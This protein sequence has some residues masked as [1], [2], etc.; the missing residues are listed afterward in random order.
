MLL[1]GTCHSRNRKQAAP[2]RQTFALC[3]YSVSV[4]LALTTLS[5]AGADLR[6]LTATA[7]TNGTLSLSFNS[8]PAFYYFL[9]AG[10]LGNS[11]NIHQLQ[12]GR[13]GVGC[14]EEPLEAS[15]SAS[16]FRIG[17]IPVT[18]PLDTDGDGIDDVYEL[19]RSG[20]LNPMDPRDAE[21]T[22]GG[23][24]SN[25]EVYRANLA[26]LSSYQREV[27]D[28]RFSLS[29][30]RALAI[31]DEGSLWAWGGRPVGDG[32]EDSKTFPVRLGTNS[33]VIA[34]ASTFYYSYAL[35]SDGTLW[36]WPRDYAAA[37]KIDP[38][39]K[40]VSLRPGAYAM[41]SDG[42]WWKITGS[43]GSEPNLI[44]I[45]HGWTSIGDLG[46]NSTTAS[47]IGVKTDG[48]LWHVLAVK[49][50][51]FPSRLGTGSNWVFASASVATALAIDAEHH[52]YEWH[53][54]VIPSSFATARKLEG[55]WSFTASAPNSGSKVGIKSDGS[56]WFWGGIAVLG[57]P[58][59]PTPTL[60]SDETD[61]V[62]ASVVDD[63]GPGLPY[64]LAA[65]R[66]SSLWGK[67]GDVI[68]TRGQTSDRYFLGQ[69]EGRDLTKG[70]FKQIGT[71]DN[72][73]QVHT[74]GDETVAVKSN[75]TLWRWGRNAWGVTN[76]VDQ[77]VTVDLLPKQ[78]G[79]NTDWKAAWIT[80]Q[81]GAAQ[82]A[83][84]SLW[85]WQHPLALLGA[86]S[87]RQISPIKV[88]SV[89]WFNGSAGTFASGDLHTL[90]LRASG[91]IYV[92]G[93][94]SFGQ[95][96][97]G[98]LSDSPTVRPLPDLYVSGWKAIAASQN[99]S[100][101]TRSNGDVY[102][103]GALPQILGYSTI[104]NTISWTNPAP[105][106]S[107]FLPL[108]T[109][110]PTDSPRTRAEVRSDGSLWMQSSYN[111]G[112]GDGAWTH[113]SQP[114]PIVAYPPSKPFRIVPEAVAV[115]DSL[116]LLID[117][118][119]D[120]E[121]REDELTTV[122]HPYAF[123]VNNNYDRPALDED[124]NVFYEDDVF[125]A[126]S[127]FTPG[128]D[129]RDADYK[130]SAGRRVI[131]TQRDLQDFA[132]LWVEGL[133]AELL[134][135][136]KVT[137]SWGDVGHADDSNPTIDVFRA[138]DPKG[139]LGYLKDQRAAEAEVDY[140]AVSYVGRLAPGEFL[141]LKSSDSRQT[142]GRLIWCGVKE[143]KGELTLSVL[144]SN[145][146]FVAQ[147]SH[148]IEL[149][150]V[151][152]MYERWTIGEDPGNTLLTHA[153]PVSDEDDELA[154]SPFQYSYDAAQDSK[155]P[156]IVFVHGWNMQPWDKDVFSNTAFKR[157]YWQGFGGRFGAFR[158]PTGNGFKG[159]LWDAMFDGH[160][161]DRSEHTAW[162]S[163]AGLLDKLRGLNSQYPGKV[164]L[165]AHSMGN[166]VAGEALR[167]AN[168]ELVVNTYVAS[169][170]AVSAHAYDP[171]VTDLVDYSHGRPLFP[172]GPF[173]GPT[174]PDVYASWFQAN[175]FAA[176]K[177]MNYYNRHDFALSADS[178]GFNQQLKPDQFLDKYGNYW[179]G[180][181]PIQGNFF[182]QHLTMGLLKIY[183]IQESLDDRYQIMAFAS[184]SR[185]R[186]LG[187]TA[188]GAGMTQNVDLAVIW[189]P[190]VSGR[191]F[192]DHFWHSAEFRG[193]AWKQW[194]Y[195]FTLLRSPNGFH[196]TD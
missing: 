125:S 85:I 54:P 147:Q 195:W 14:F 36:A 186:P 154:R 98:T 18:S 78:V 5:L 47:L 194:N 100:M 90:E 74:D 71:D 153:V 188:L 191:S 96:G 38:T 105:L 20:R 22:F 39:A 34:V 57:G 50:F 3:I 137:L 24:H 84:G 49:S 86:L 94:N 21:T 156:Y 114:I 82:K 19:R 68:E 69:V 161:F 40:W 118:N 11:T 64:I 121:L 111:Y 177:L 124:D 53:A 144:E 117:V 160:N 183:N 16:F 138:A 169:Q 27:W 97:T 119:H 193:E 44:P 123:W 172:S 173:Y 92:V 9:E 109:G 31:R 37:T 35:N 162:H 25:L 1:L 171:G 107:R 12:L 108:L 29:E 130:D 113:P 51:M 167:L 33:D 10:S 32:T 77:S 4:H 170:A 58:E 126:D 151:R 141:S 166:I 48:T 59:V 165:L 104:T 158:W 73:I 128:R 185:A 79:R 164:Y 157:L 181:D 184:E 26:A 143:G 30:F 66:D 28:T 148:Y 93:S 23:L 52:L 76:N 63:L 132:R 175:K 42:S 149:R 55:E 174:T 145:G 89:A 122:D 103:W 80:S 46:G 83:D 189:P 129:T 176:G 134:A 75:G 110:L 56:L 88:P 81:F 72:W 87:E 127:P 179:Y 15:A 192:A 116:R 152:R 168:R 61:W 142:S 159:T 91:A 139:G 133:T 67:G 190:D 7:I 196:I 41:K 13:L 136:G 70:G 140:S 146:A 62:A 45:G 131:P 150:E 187:A 43:A 60:I 135:S 182:L 2:W 102:A 180:Y 106:H 17:K 112:N 120:G 155:V 101:A 115:A 178:W 6:F 8:D 99:Y 163:G 95:L 65:K